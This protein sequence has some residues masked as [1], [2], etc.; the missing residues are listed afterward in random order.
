MGCTAAAHNIPI[1]AGLI[2]LPACAAGVAGRAIDA[3]D[4]CDDVVKR[5][6]KYD[7]KEA[8][9]TDF[10]PEYGYECIKPRHIKKLDEIR[11]EHS[12]KVDMYQAPTQYCV[13]EK[14]YASCT[15]GKWIPMI[16]PRGQVCSQ[17]TTNTTISCSPI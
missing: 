4:R 16:C 8:F 6:I 3:N 12:C 5:Q 17:S 1:G 15:D 13:G 7:S 14:F 9:C 10:G 11:L 2:I